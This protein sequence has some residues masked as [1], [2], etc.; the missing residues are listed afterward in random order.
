MTEGPIWAQLEMSQI[1]CCLAGKN[2]LTH[3][4]EDAR[5]SPGGKIRIETRSVDL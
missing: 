2:E 5:Q 4:H 1:I 3:R